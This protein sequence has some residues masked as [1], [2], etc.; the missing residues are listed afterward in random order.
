MYGFFIHIEGG[1]FCPQHMEE[2]MRYPRIKPESNTFYHAYN[3]AAGTKYDRPYGDAEKEQFLR[4]MKRLDSFYVVDVLA[5]T[6]MS[7]HFHLL[8]HA[9]EEAPSHEETC[10]RYKAYY[11]AEERELK[12]GSPRCEEISQRLRDVSWFMHDL[13]RQFSTWFN[14]TRSIRRRG[15]L[16]AGRFKSTVLEAGVAVWDCWQYIE[17]NAVVVGMAEDASQYRFCSLG[18]WA[19]RGRHPFEDNAKRILLPTLGEFLREKSLKS[20]HIR[21][22]RELALQEAM[23]RELQ[24]EVL[25]ETL[26]KINQPV[27]FHAQAIHQARY[28]VDG[29][30]IGSELFVKELM[31]RVRGPAH[32]KKRRLTKAV[33]AE[34]NGVQLVCYKQLRHLL[35]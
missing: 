13:Q 19:G 31:T 2:A 22:R 12:P 9:P 33:E 8:L 29:A 32:M 21:I 7:N 25:E 18:Q 17:M 23:R 28:W 30:V 11:A 5:F 34:A 26:K 14:S 27:K 4:I 20:L 10:R 3:R 6:C 24:P 16:W 35:E 15:T 1:C